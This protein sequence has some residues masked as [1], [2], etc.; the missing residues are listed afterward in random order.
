MDQFDLSGLNAQLEKTVRLL[1]QA[2][3]SSSRIATNL[4]S[5]MSGGSGGVGQGGR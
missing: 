2:E 1:S 3:A 4:S 5:G